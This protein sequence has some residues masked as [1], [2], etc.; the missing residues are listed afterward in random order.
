MLNDCSLPDSRMLEC[1]PTIGFVD[2]N[3]NT[4]STSLDVEPPGIPPPPPLDRAF[5]LSPDVNVEDEL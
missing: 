5:R 2:V 1:A 4:L 3:N